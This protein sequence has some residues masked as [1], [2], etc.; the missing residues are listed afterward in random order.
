MSLTVFINCG[1]ACE[2]RDIPE[3]DWKA[4]DA[5]CAEFSENHLW[6]HLSTQGW[7]IYSRVHKRW[8]VIASSAVPE[9]IKM[10]RLLH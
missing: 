9:I 7:C 3:F 1:N 8:K 6:A 2:V 5:V 10:A 4:L